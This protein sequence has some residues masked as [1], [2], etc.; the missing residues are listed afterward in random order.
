VLALVPECH[1]GDASAT[2]DEGAA[3]RT[4]DTGQDTTVASLS[5]GAAAAVLGVH[6]RTIR[7]AIARGDL[8][9][10]KR[11]GVYRIVPAD[12][13]R[14][15]ARRP[16]VVSPPTPAPFPA[17]HLV[18][19]PRREDVVA[20]ALPLPLTPLI[21]REREVAAVRDLVLRDGVRLVTLTGPGGVGKTRLALRVAE[22]LAAGFADG[23]AFVPLAAVRDPALVASAIAQ[24]LGVREAADRP[25]AE[26]VARHLRDRHL[27]LLLDNF[28]QV[29]AAAPLVGDLLAAAPGLRV[30]VTS[31]S[32]LRLYGEVGVAVPPLTLPPPSTLPLPAQV[33]RF[34][35]VRLFVERAQ[36]APAGFRLTAANA[37]VIAAICRHLDGLP[38]A[39]ELA[40]AR[41]ALLP[42][43][44]LLA[45]LEQR[46]P[47]LTGGARDQPDRHRTM[48][49]AI[50][51]SYDL[52]SPEEQAL[53]RR[54]AVFVG[55]FTLEAAE[56][57]CGPQ[58]SGGAPSGSRRAS[59]ERPVTPDA[60]VLDGV[61]SLVDQSLVDLVW[62]TE[63]P[64][65]GAPGDERAG[66]APRYRMLE[67]VREFGLEQ[68]AATGEEDATRRA[69]AAWCLD[70][71]ERHWESILSLAFLEGLDRIEADYDNLRAAFAWLEQAGDAEGMLRLT[72]SLGEFWLFH[73]YR[74]EGRAW[75]ARA[76]ALTSSTAIPATVR[77]RALRA[78]GVL[79][80]G[81][82]DHS[83]ASVAAGESLALWRGLGDRQGT[84]L[85]LHLLGL[86]AVVQADYVQ[87]AV[88]S[89]EAQAIF[90]ALGNPWWAA[91][92]RSDVLG[93][94]VWGRGD[95]AAAAAILEESLAVYRDLE[96]P[97][98]A[99]VAL[100]YL[101]FIACD[102]GDR[103][104]AAARFAAALPLWRQLGAREMQANW[105]AGVAT[106]A[107][108]HRTP[109]RA[110][111][112]FGAAEALCVE[113][114]HAFSLPERAA[115]DRAAAGTRAALGDTDFAAAWAAGRTQ[116]LDQSLD[117]AS[118]FL[119]L[120]A[121]HGP[122][123]R[124]AAS[125]ADL[126]RRERD[127]LRLLVAGRSDKEIA[128]ALFVGMRTVQSHA[129][130]I[131]AKLGVRNRH[132]A[133]AVAVRRGLV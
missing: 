18:P 77:A 19:F 130:K 17:P 45:R 54:L 41:V 100:N 51:W 11:G 112:L 107:A 91:G 32:V 104:A 23:V 21:G 57:V 95:P 1:L 88:H 26:G 119:A 43:A 31:R 12:L 113:L 3:D 52:L 120:I 2:M 10:S 16:S 46:L 74:Q 53:F 80:Q 71:A 66:D 97:L 50:A 111:R 4:P 105:L 92:V 121:A 76:F 73:S 101:G 42:P 123:P 56:A 62:Q 44:A 70:L 64:D 93:P 38:L 36:A 61:G 85:A 30:L 24:V 82:G 27:L 133:T 103:A 117:E 25:V 126:T 94:A 55:G 20:P 98:N 109:K 102:R 22:A 86:V 81:R 115:F 99:A 67:T 13:A 72:G 90:E 60:S 29:L 63:P 37:P 116:P 87:A 129:E 47:L 7:R 6:E 75:L 127:V 68:L 110:A 69:H 33:A 114:G 15:Q 28:E 34:D 106:L 124:G 108:L 39:I 125:N 84:A 40:A 89:A 79:A 131:Y 65:G 35:A 132:E 128:A 59:G 58:A 48:R 122:E 78:A 5:A 8:P 49:G 96:D 14:Y 9:A 118:E 83:R